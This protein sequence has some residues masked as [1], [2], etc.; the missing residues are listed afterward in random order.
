MFQMP[1]F[2]RL[3]CGW[4]LGLSLFGVIACGHRND[5][6]SAPV[7]L[8]PTT[9]LSLGWT[10]GC[11]VRR[12]GKVLCWGG[13]SIVQ[14]ESI[15]RTVSDTLL[16]KDVPGIADAAAISVEDSTAFGC[17]LVA[18]GVVRCWGT[19]DPGIASA[20]AVS[21]GYRHF[22]A[23]LEDGTIQCWGGSDAGELGV[24]STTD[25]DVPRPVLGIADA[26]GVSAGYD[27]TCAVLTDGTARCWG[28]NNYGQ[29]GDGTTAERTEP[30]AVLGLTNTVEACTGLAHSCARLDDGTIRCWGANSFGQLG[31]G[32]RADSTAPVVVMGITHAT[33]IACGYNHTCAR[34]DDGSIQCWGADGGS[35]GGGNA[36]F[37]ALGN[38]GVTQGCKWLINGGPDSASTT[39]APTP[40][41]V[42]GIANAVMVAAGLYSSCAVLADGSARC[43][44]YN[45]YGQLGDG[46]TADSTVPVTVLAQSDQ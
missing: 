21:G 40:V 7:E 43:W 11:A 1:R 41:P 24:G 2:R 9:A 8:R 16:A 28:A 30:V 26:V 17:A 37:G 10:T 18:G 5:L 19:A 23:L 34:L 4:W 38:P 36:S 20:V 35:I 46:T 42:T 33:T 22:C 31:D 29:L 13:N 27:A 45:L 39:C 14:D 3:G 6:D 44:G 25:S 32:T 15:A 12:D